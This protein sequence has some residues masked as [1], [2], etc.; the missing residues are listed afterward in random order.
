MNH[1][2]KQSVLVWSFVC[3]YP[4]LPG[5]LS[6]VGTVYA[7]V[8]FAGGEGSE[9]EPFQIATAE[10]LNEI[11]NHLDKHFVLIN[12]IDLSTDASTIAWEPIANFSGSLDGNEK[13]ITNLKIHKGSNHV[14]LFANVLTGGR[15]ENL[16]IDAVE[17]RGWDYVGILV[18]S[19]IG[20]INN[21]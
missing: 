15:I 7:A 17:V 9:D 11:R 2:K 12:D 8:G 14:G 20:V 10:H 1:W 3:C 6:S 5:V 18:G 19:N 21:S 13:S 16:V 4:Y